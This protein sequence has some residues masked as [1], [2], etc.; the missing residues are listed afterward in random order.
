M[1][2]G[3]LQP[4]DVPQ[5]LTNLQNRTLWLDKLRGRVCY[6]PVVQVAEQFLREGTAVL[7]LDA[8]EHVATQTLAEGV[9]QVQFRARDGQR[10]A[11]TVEAAAPLVTYPSS[12]SLVPKNVP[13]FRRA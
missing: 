8:Y 3:R 10:H 7:H 4:E 6:E 9:W 2:Y 12:G 13:Q 11:V 1:N 5:L